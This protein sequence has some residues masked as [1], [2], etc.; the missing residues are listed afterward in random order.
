[1]ILYLGRLHL[2][3]GCDL[4]ID[5]FSEVVHTDKNLHLVFIG[6][7]QD[8]WRSE[9]ESKVEQLGI[10]SHVSWLGMVDEQL[11]WGGLSAADV[12]ILPSHSENFGASVV[13]A[14]SCAT[15]V[16]ISNKVN[17]WREIKN[18]EAGFVESDDL[19]GTIRLLKKWLS[20]KNNEKDEMIKR[21]KECFTKNFEIFIFNKDSI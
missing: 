2:K 15:P 20:L 3:K 14:L 1:V 10:D 8:G 21:S 18:S 11:K 6:N 16:L 19:E 13:E 7:D 9:L 4:L 5:A 17:I 12:F